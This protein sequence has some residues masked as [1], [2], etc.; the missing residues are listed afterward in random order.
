MPK[1]LLQCLNDFETVFGLVICEQAFS[2][3]EE[4]SRLLQKQSRTVGESRRVTGLLR[5]TLTQMQSANSFE[6]V[7]DKCTTLAH[8]L[9][10]TA[11][12]LPRHKK[13][14][15]R[16]TE[17]DE[18]ATSTHPP[19]SILQHFKEKHWDPMISTMIEAKVSY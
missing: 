7:W 4:V 13:P 3:L 15:R 19:D 9:N 6:K 11:P 5:S 10:V 14:P 2:K 12:C 17:D 8:E 18:I 1:S 16:L